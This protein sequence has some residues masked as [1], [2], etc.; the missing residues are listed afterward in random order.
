[1]TAPA[2]S[3]PIPLLAPGTHTLGA[4]VAL[5]CLL[6]V[7]TLGAQDAGS[8]RGR[9]VDEQTREPIPGVLIR[10]HETELTAVS[11]PDGRF[12]IASIPA[13]SAVV[14]LNHIGYGEH[15]RVVVVRPGA[16][17]PLQARLAP[18]AIVL[19]EVVAEGRTELDQRRR[20]QGFS[21]NEIR[22]ETIDRA[23][24]Q[25]LNL[26]QLLQQDMLGV[27][28]RG[29][30]VEYRGSAS[31]DDGLCREVS[32]FIDG[33]PITAPSTIYAN[34]PLHDIERLEVMSPGEAGAQY[35]SAG[36]WGVLMVETRRGTRPDR[37]AAAKEEMVVGFDWEAEQRSYRWGR[38]ASGSL[39]GNAL[40]LGLSLVAADQCFRIRSRG[41]LGVRQRCNAITTMASGLLT[42]S[43]P[44]L[45]GSYA[46][47]W[48]G[49]TERSRGRIL[50]GLVLGTI[51]AATGYLL[52][53]RGESWEDDAMMTAGTVV[54]T[55]GTP[56]LLLL[57]D[58]TL[59]VLR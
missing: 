26:G 56:A 41:V 59:R 37:P 45:T 58:R 4:W 22:R 14:Y 35:G 40:G 49:S 36:G 38:A 15:L 7:G 10:I 12:A 19:P 29:S 28:V 32:V 33:V 6:F 44:S 23:S 16:E 46:A 55:I 27:R 57:S 30:C 52:L 47:R 51:S 2:H 42:L 24:L 20:S 48:G 17:T 18:R 9:V 34:M 39:I 1:M 43:L 53:V 50:P 11:G 5:A 25:G 13:G 21:M 8:L 31:F 54:L 3:H